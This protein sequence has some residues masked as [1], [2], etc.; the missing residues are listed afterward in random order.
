MDYIIVFNPYHINM[1]SSVCFTGQMEDNNG[2]SYPVTGVADL[3]LA[4]A[5]VDFMPTVLE[6]I[7]PQWNEQAASTAGNQFDPA[8]DR[9]W[10]LAAHCGGPYVIPA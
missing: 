4:T 5:G 9:I 3:T 7:I 2:N 8:N 1:S 10:C 6:Q